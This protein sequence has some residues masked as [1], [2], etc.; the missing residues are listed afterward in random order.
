M[1]KIR[2]FM[3]FPPHSCMLQVLWNIVVFCSTLTL[4]DGKSPSPQKLVCRIVAGKKA[5]LD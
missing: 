1:L 5:C 3:A 4:S 2:L